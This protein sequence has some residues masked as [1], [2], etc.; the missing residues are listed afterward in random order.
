MS[1]P[2]SPDKK[3]PKAVFIAEKG[4][5]YRLAYGDPTIQTAPV[6][7]REVMTYLRHGK[8]AAQWRLAA[9]PEG[10]VSYGV[11][12]QARLFFVRHGM[13]LF[14]ALVMFVLGVLILRALKHAKP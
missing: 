12:A 14:S 9:A 1:R 7:E 11:F 4:E 10:A 2:L 8:D 6:Y 5:R 3:E 13:L